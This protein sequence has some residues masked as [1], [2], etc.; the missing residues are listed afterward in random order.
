MGRCKV[1]PRPTLRVA[2]HCPMEGGEGAR[3]QIF[4]QQAETVRLVQPGGRSSLPVTELKPGDPLLLRWQHKG[5][6]IGRPIAASVV[7]K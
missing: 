5:T 6:H 3:G 4:L 2:F 1:E 7:E